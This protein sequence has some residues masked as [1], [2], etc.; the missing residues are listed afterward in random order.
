MGADSDRG[1]RVDAA[2][3]S[4]EYFLEGAEGHEEFRASGGKTLTA[5]LRR[6]LELAD[7]RPG[8]R[9]LDLA[10]G[11]GELVLH[12]ALRGAQT[13]GIDFAP[14]ALDL[15]RRSVG[16]SGEGAS[17][18]LVR[19]DA[20]CLGLRGAA[21]DVVLM[22]DFVE[23]VRQGEL[24]RALSEAHRAL[25]PGGRLV[26]HTSPNRVF[27]QV[28]YP[29]YVRNVHRLLMGAARRLRVEGRFFNEIVMPTDP[30]PPHDEYERRLHV[31]AQSAGSLREC[32][33]R[34]GFRARRIEFWEPPHGPFFE[35]RLRWHNIL[36][37][38]LDVVRFL[39]PFSRFPP[40]DRL[41]SNHIWVVAQRV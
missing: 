36:V 18:G 41:F 31:N 10:C 17:A 32:L 37:G 35:R 4:R 24:E 29:R 40:L 38:A 23:H 7:P 2:A 34:N 8:E 13:I 1:T 22:L 26:I 6:G 5:R 19:M 20:G 3:Y 9:M 14:A 30:V 16:G 28:V 33:E 25:R 11:R 21:F 15:A 12:G 27:E 39:R